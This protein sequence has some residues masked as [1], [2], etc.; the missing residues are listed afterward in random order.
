M[1]EY[2]IGIEI[3]LLSDEFGAEEKLKRSVMSVVPEGTEIQTYP[4][5][6]CNSV[7]FNLPSLPPPIVLDIN[8]EERTFEWKLHDPSVCSE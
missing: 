5:K 8:G 7:I 3:F 2:A 4:H 6:D 1:N